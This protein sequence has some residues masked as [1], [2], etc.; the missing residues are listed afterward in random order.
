M[1]GVK[2]NI[3][4]LFANALFA[5]NYSIFA[6]LVGRGVLSCN[7][8]FL[9]QMAS[10]FLVALPLALLRGGGLFSVRWRDLLQIGAT[11]MVSSFGWGYLTLKG[12]SYTSPIDVATIATLGPSLTLIFAHLLHR[13]ALTL[14]RI[15][16]LLLSL[17]GAIILLLHRG[18][19]LIVGSEGFGNLLIM[20]GVLSAAINTLMIER[21][22]ERYG[23]RVV[24]GWYAIFSFG[25]SLLLFGNELPSLSLRELSLGGFGEL[26]YVVA[27]GSVVPIF[28]L[29]RGTEHLTPLHTSL[30]RYLQPFITSLIVVARGQG[31]LSGANYI[32][33]AVLVAGG[34]LLSRGV[35]RGV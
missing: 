21:P 1:K 29:F 13:R 31:E 5:I 32:A 27:L 23:L 19:L 28:M 30:Y 3:D 14:P 4:L 25:V 26:G 15:V 24:M 11:A 6:S 35:G 20:V 34:V 9:L 12:L 7:Q 17:L 10:L 2:Y 18:K 8:I 22:I 16:G 33:I